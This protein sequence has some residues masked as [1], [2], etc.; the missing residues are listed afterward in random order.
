M[1]LRL[2]RRGQRGR[3]LRELPAQE[4]RPARAS[5]YPDSAR[6]RLQPP[7]SLSMSLRR[8][9]VLG[10]VAVA[11]VLGVAGFT[12]TSTLRSYLLTRVDNQL[13]AVPALSGF[14]ERRLPDSPFSELAFV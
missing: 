7:A 1:G 11:I 14:S 13:A 8:R 2:R 9:V 5:A 10:M 3:D 6:L 4:A 12:I